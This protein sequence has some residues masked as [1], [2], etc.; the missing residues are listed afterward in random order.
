MDK[1]IVARADYVFV[2]F[3]YGERNPFYETIRYGKK[4]I[5]SIINN[6]A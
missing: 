2:G 5:H 3:H 1:A 6:A 4:A